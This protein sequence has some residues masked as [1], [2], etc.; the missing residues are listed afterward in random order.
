MEREG[1]KGPRRGRDSWWGPEACGNGREADGETRADIET[2]RFWRRALSRLSRMRPFR[3]GPD[4]GAF[5]AP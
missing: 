3:A 4:A 1:T 2:A 5:G